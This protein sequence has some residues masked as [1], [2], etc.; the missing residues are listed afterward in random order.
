MSCTGCRP[1]LLFRF[2]HLDGWIPLVDSKEEIRRILLAGE[3][4]SLHYAC[5]AWGFYDPTG[6]QDHVKLAG[7]PLPAR[8]LI[9]TVSRFS[10]F[11]S[12]SRDACREVVK[13]SLR[14]RRAVEIDLNETDSAMSGE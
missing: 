4:V 12:R 5:P 9:I 6:N 11:Q 2:H 10:F 3:W 1:G 14:A 7:I 13:H 8:F